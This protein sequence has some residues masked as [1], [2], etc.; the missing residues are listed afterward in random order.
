MELYMTTLLDYKVASADIEVEYEILPLVD[1]SDS[2][3][4]AVFDGLNNVNEYLATNQ[5]R[6]D[7]LNKEIDHLTNHADGIDYMVAV[8]S[9]ILAG[10]VD[11]FWVGAFDFNR[12]KA[13][14]NKKVNEFVMKVAKSKG[15][16]GE[17]LD[18]AIKF[19]EDK[20]K[21]PSDNIWS[22]KEIGVSA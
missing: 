19:L 16:K 1:E 17:R 2:R 21:I 8:G 15:Y 3:K 10:I 14:S 20:F 22:G 12:G 13:W 9:G 6:V 7:E 18:G 5:L 11:S 4:K